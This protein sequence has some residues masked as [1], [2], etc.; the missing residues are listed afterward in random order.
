MTPATRNI[1]ELPNGS[2]S[3]TTA[4][5]VRFIRVASKRDMHMLADL[6]ALVVQQKQPQVRV[7]R[8]GVK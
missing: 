8:Q 7:Q 4:D 3:G 5:G 1:V 6:K 2:V